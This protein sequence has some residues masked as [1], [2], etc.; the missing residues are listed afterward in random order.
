MSKQLPIYDSGEADASTI[1]G[2]QFRHPKGGRWNVLS[3]AG[4]DE[5]HVI[6]LGADV[7]KSRADLQPD[8]ERAATFAAVAV[9]E[10]QQLAEKHGTPR[11]T[12]DVSEAYGELARRLCAAYVSWHQ[13]LKG[14]DYALKRYASDPV[15]AYWQQLA[16]RVT[17]EMADAVESK[18][19]KLKL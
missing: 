3:G 12:D 8:S 4:D 11:A 17:R 16:E 6:V 18:L 19:S 1:S 9:K 5:L 10:F 14:V 7:Q 2:H 13:R 15:G